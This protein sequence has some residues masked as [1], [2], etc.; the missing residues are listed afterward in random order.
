MKSSKNTKE[1]HLSKKDF[2][3][4]TFRCGGKGGQNVNKR[5]TGVRITHI[6]TGISCESREHRTQAM[7]KKAAFRRLADKLIEHFF[8]KVIPERFS[9][10]SQVIRTYH[11]PD[12]RITDHDSGEKFSFRHTVGKGDVSELIESRIRFFL[13]SKE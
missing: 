6:E 4:D 1:L 8:P 5:D 11:E 7:N 10:G 9:A 3:V 13:G 12:D 2:R